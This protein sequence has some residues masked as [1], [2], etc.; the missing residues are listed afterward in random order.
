MNDYYHALYNYNLAFNIDSN[1]N[2]AILGILKVNYLKKNYASN[3]NFSIHLDLNFINDP[4]IFIFLAKSN[5]ESYKNDNNSK[6]NYL[7]EEKYH[8]TAAFLNLAYNISNEDVFV[9]KKI[10]NMLY[11]IQ[12]YTNVKL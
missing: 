4:W 8:K 2:E 3:M 9:V 6:E 5:Y 11:K 1:N 10:V 7:E 12:F